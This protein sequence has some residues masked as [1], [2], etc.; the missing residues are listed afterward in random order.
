MN[1]SMFLTKFNATLLDE[2]SRQGRRLWRLDLPLIYFSGMLGTIVTVPAGFV[3]DLESAPRWPIVY[4][5]VGD[6][7]QEPAALH[8]FVYSRGMFTRS[9]CDSLLKEASETTGTPAWKA[10]LI[11]AG[12][13]VGGA[14]HYGSQYTT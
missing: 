10:A 1:G 7:V 6:L 2:R 14:G 11:W 5:L 4:W 13:R 9:I 12:V 3:T 8:D